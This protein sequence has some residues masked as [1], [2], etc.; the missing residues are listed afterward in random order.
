MKLNFML[1]AIETA[2]SSGS[3]IPIGAVIVKDNEIIAS[4]SNE[5]EK[6]QNALA[7]A[8]MI[9]IKRANEKL[10][11]RR[12]HHPRCGLLFAERDISD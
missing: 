5:R 4:A 7:H 8:E 10:K 11:T 12:P 6:T 9:A 1:K 2:E 3:D